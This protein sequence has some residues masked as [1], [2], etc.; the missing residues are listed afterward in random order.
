MWQLSNRRFQ[1]MIIHVVVVLSA[2]YPGIAAEKLYNGIVLPDEWPPRIKQL[3]REPMPVPYLEHPPEVI[4][5]DVGRQLFVDDFLIEQTT[6]KRT[7]HAARYHPDCPVLKPDK[8]WENDSMKGKP[9]KATA[10][11]FGDGVWYDPAD[12]LFKMWYMGSNLKRT[13]YATSKDGIH[14]GKPSLD[15]V[16][17]TNILLDQE[18]DSSTV[19]LDLNERDPSRRYK[20]FTTVPRP[21]GDG[22]K[23]AIYYSAD[24]INWGEPLIVGGG[25][26]DRSTIFYNPFRERWV[27]SIRSLIEP[28]GR[29]RRYAECTDLV[30]GLG[31][32]GQIACLW[33]TADRL[34]PRNPNPALK[35]T[36]PQLYNLDVVPYESLLVGLFS[37]W[38]GKLKGGFEKRNEVLVGYTRDGFHWHRPY[39]R[40]FAGVNETKGAWNYANVQSCASGCLVMG[41]YLYFYVSGRGRTG[42]PAS[43]GL[44]VL[45]R[46]GFASMD[47]GETTGTLTTRPLRFTGKQL[48]VNAD[49]RGGELRVEVLDS[50]GEVYPALARKRCMPI[51]TDGTIQP[52]R[53]LEPTDL[54]ALA[55]KLVR[56]RFHLTHGKLY[57]FW[58]SPDQ[59]GA[60]HGYVAAGGPGYTSPRDTVGRS[61]YEA[62][63]RISTA[64]V[65]EKSDAIRSAY[66]PGSWE[67]VALHAPFKPR[68]CA[69]GFVLDGKMWLSNGWYPEGITIRDLWCSSKDG[70][71]WKLVSD[72]TPYDPYSRMVVYAGKVWA[73]YNSVWN[74]DDGIHWHKVLDKAPCNAGAHQGA[75]VFK[76]R[77]WLLGSDPSVWW[78]TDG[79]KWTCATDHASYGD[80]ASCAVASYDGRL[81]LMGGR[82]VG[83]N[84]PPELCYKDYT[85]YNDVWCSEDGA[86]WTRVL[87]HAPWPP[88]MWPVAAV[89]DGRLWLIGGFDNVHRKNLGGVWTTQDGRTWQRFHAIQQFAPRHAVTRYIFN[90]SLW[91]V[92]GNTWPVVNDVWRL[93]LPIG[94][95]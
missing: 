62:V 57:S 81:W 18:R 93:T 68:D 47:A 83:A 50:N 49:A 86:N 35:E 66:S 88:R 43:T 74:S 12:K 16:P 38:Q 23:P 44:A 41:D 7:V 31:N 78:T 55:S 33:L 1:L 79:V 32:L 8:P 37:I 9:R 29:S 52:V 76:D 63:A 75:V 84:N 17:G 59:S 48:F 89:Y 2:G 54:A 91:V 22:F 71:S 20:M 26:G 94:E 69:E 56:F 95:K 64:A 80:R 27:Y 72:N 25:I 15:I 70:H 82:M 65:S 36:D 67:C 21:Q 34:D 6:L 42:E 11:V 73:I 61:A 28:W 5:I 77:I 87:E 14:W 58:V 13:C 92:A 40:P 90:D 60:S 85:T 45:R 4:P 30:E 24:G 46:D 19:W 51:T 3:S 10:I 39:R 53:W